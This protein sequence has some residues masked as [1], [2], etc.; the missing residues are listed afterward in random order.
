MIIFENVVDYSFVNTFDIEK[1]KEALVLPIKKDG[2]Y[3]K[4]FVC[5][6]SNIELIYSSSLIKTILISKVDIEFFLSD[7][8]I[9]LKLYYLSQKSIIIDDIN[10]Q[11][12]EDFFNT[13]ARKAIFSRASDIHIEAVHNSLCIRFRVDGQLKIF[14]IFNKEFSIVLS[15]Y[16][17]MLSKL[18]ITQSRL[19]MDS[20]FSLLLDKN[21]YD[22][23]VSTMPTIEGESIVLR[24]LHDKNINK[25][26][27]DLGFSNHIYEEIK[28]IT[29]LTTGLVLIT[30]P[31]G[32]GKSTTLYSIIK[33]LNTQNKKIITI[34]DPV[35][36]KV[37]QIQ[38]I[39]VNDSIGLS[40]DVILK[41]ILRQD[42]D[43]ILIA[44]IRDKYSLDVAL[45][46][47]LTG[48]LVLASI[49]ANNSVETL[50]RLT[51]LKADRYLLSSTLKYIISQRLVLNICK[52]CNKKG[53]DICNYSG[54]YERSSL[55]EVLKVDN[56]ISS[57]IFNHNDLENINEYLKKINFKTMLDDGKDKVKQNITSLEEVYKVL[58]N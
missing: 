27:Q 23:R 12:I 31:T 36:Y 18:D 46:A 26:I 42:P 41:N 28:N 37:E 58:G 44:E 9:R 6:D 4:C 22:F 47:S 40:F 51:D 43:I 21:K 25:K 52:N 17:K 33:K 7:F 56:T 55:A 24:I 34:E 10:H 35:E 45:Q 30:G 53:C 2:I 38:Q 32:S 54:F 57:M 48:H 39:P 20:R 13:L 14:F 49:H 19:P 5:K 3:I 29:K 50:S 15:S 8:E 1:L 16:I 11:Y